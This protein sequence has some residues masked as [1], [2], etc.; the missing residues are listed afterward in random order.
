M[1]K[2][3][4]HTLTVGA[5]TAV[6]FPPTLTNDQGFTSITEPADKNTT[7]LVKNGDIMIWK[8][9]EDIT[10]LKA[11]TE[12][13]GDDVFSSN[14]KKQD[15]GTWKATV[16]KFPSGNTQSYSITYVV[17]GAPKPQYTQDP[18]LKMR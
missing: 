1:C 3:T 12:T 2:T 4:I 6:P 11:I 10:D 17:K 18:K 13:G 16:G 5:T 7:T 9:S 14:P 15:D 8:K